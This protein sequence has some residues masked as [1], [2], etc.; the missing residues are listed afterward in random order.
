MNELNHHVCSPCRKIE[1]EMDK[2]DV[3]NCHGLR[4]SNENVSVEIVEDQNQEH[5]TKH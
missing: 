3:Y 1:Q 2:T 4:V 5:S